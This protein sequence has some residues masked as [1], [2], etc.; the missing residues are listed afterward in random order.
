MLLSNYIEDIFLDFFSFVNSHGLPLQRQD[1]APIE[2]FYNVLLSGNQLT[3]AQA[4]YILKILHKYKGLTAIH[5]LD[6][7]SHLDAP[8]W[9]NKFRVL[10]TSKRVFVQTGDDGIIHVCLKFPYQLKKAFEDTLQ[11]VKVSSMWDAEEKVRKINLYNCNLVQIGEFVHHHGFEI[12]DSFL[13]VLG[14]VEE[15]WA[16]QSKISM[17][18]IIS[19]NAVELINASDDALAYWNKQKTGKIENDL[20]LAKSMGFLLD[21]KAETIFERIAATKPTSYWVKTNAELLALC[22]QIDG[23]VCI[24]LDRVGNTRNWLTEFAESIDT[25]G[26]ARDQVKVCFRAEKNDNSQLNETIKEYGF[27]GKVEEGKFLIFNHKPAKWLFKDTESVKILVS[28]NLYPS[29]NA[30]TRDWFNSHPLVIYVG[31]IKP[32]ETRNNNIVEL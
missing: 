1:E 19:N 15:I 26:I 23:K 31:N 27:G 20:I 28:N 8:Q 7:T 17:R 2:S 5:G 16:N 18:S 29:T 24:V 6:Y 4:G 3:E 30:L 11:Q 10:D 14:Q 12:D 13:Q 9:R 21:K 22:N 25:A 32:S